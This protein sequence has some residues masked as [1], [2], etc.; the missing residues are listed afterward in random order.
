MP[1]ITLHTHI[2]APQPIVF[3]L[4]RSID[5]HTY[6]TRH[7]NETAIAGRIEGLIELG[8]SVTWRARHFGVYQTLTSRITAYERPHYFID[9]M[10]SGAFKRFE[11]L[12][13]FEVQGDATRMTDV[14]DYT[15]P[16]GWLGRLADVLLL[17]RYMTRLL[18]TRNQV[19]RAC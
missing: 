18:A 13:R 8:E 1:T 11:H 2:R 12:H 9:E 17:E 4:A 15:S 16:L 6:S 3:D 5:L 19:I 7:T 14:F 10:V